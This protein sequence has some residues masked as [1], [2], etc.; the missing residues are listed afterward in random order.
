MILAD[1][2][3]SGWRPGAK[4]EACRELSR[5]AG[6]GANASRSC[7]VGPA[8]DAPGGSFSNGGAAGKGNWPITKAEHVL[9]GFCRPLR[10]AAVA[11]GVAGLGH[12]LIGPRAGEQ[13]V[14]LGVHAVGICAD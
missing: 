1:G 14:D 4:V 13:L 3:R 10:G 2:P 11:V 5:S 12:R 9:D 8:G 7:T 6:L